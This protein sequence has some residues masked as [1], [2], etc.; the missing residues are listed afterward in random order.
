MMVCRSLCLW[1]TTVRFIYY[2][3]AWVCPGVEGFLDLVYVPKEM[4]QVT[5]WSQIS[6]SLLDVDEE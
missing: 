5:S 2:I 4:Y 3:F 1:H 6:S